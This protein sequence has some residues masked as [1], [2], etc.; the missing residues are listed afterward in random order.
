MEKKYTKDRIIVGAVVLVMVFARQLLRPLG[1]ADELWNYDLSRG[2]AMGYIPYR[3]Y[4]MLQMPLFFMLMSLPLRLS[5]TL[6]MYRIVSSLMLSAAA[7]FFYETARK[8]LGAA[9]SI[10]ATVLGI[11]F[12]DVATYNTLLF[13]FIMTSYVLLKKEYTP[14]TGH[15]LGIF[16]ALGILSRQT[17]GVFLTIACLI[18]LIKGKEQKGKKAGAFILGASVPCL[19]FLIYLLATGSFF[20]FWDYCFFSLL[21]KGQSNTAFIPDSIPVLLIIAGGI[22]SDIIIYRKKKEEKVLYHLVLTAVAATIAIPIVDMMHLSYAA[23][24]S[25]IPI[26]KI[27]KETGREEMK[28]KICIFG[29]TAIAIF[30]LFTDVL[31][32]LGSVMCKG[33]PELVLIPTDNGIYETYVYISEINEEYKKAGYKV[34]FFSSGA[35]MDS[36]ITGDINPP[37]D[38]FLR[39]NLG[40]TDPLDYAV[41]A[42]SDPYTLILIPDDYDT[43]NYQNPEGIYSYITEH[44]TK[45]DSYGRFSWYLPDM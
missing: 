28:K 29:I 19:M 18:L 14:H 8:E 27:L 40:T 10:F 6:L 38:V 45:I 39:G 7:L 11:I 12:F 16:C 3:D 2:L 15:A 43:E 20:D 31:G 4:N 42:C 37:Y 25:W 35:V 44:C 13:F 34:A 41:S 9:Y 22:I 5:R 24:F 23:M 21:K 26:L 32:N 33:S 1:L 30:S 36:I 17:T